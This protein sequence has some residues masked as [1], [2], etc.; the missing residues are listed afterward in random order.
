[1]VEA[2]RGDVADAAAGGA[3]ALLPLLLVT[4]DRDRLVEAAG[5]LEGAAPDRD[6]RAPRQRH[7]AVGRAGVEGGDRRLLTAAG[8]RAAALQEGVDRAGEDVDLGRRVGCR[9]QRRQPRR[10]RPHV[11][12]DEDQQLARGG[13]DAGVAGGVGA[14]RRRQG[15]DARRAARRPR[16]WPDRDRRAPPRPRR[17][18]PPPAARSTRAR[19]RGSR[20][21]R[22]SARRWW[23]ALL[24]QRAEVARLRQVLLAQPR[25]GRRDS[26]AHADAR[27]PAEQLS[28]SRPTAS[29]ARR[30]PRRSA[31]APVSNAAGSS[32]HSS[33]MIRA[34][35][36]IVSSSEAE[37]LKSSLSAAGGRSRRRSRRRCRRCG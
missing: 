11:V 15:D 34:V 31:G 26:L 37:M 21:G 33:Q 5:G 25:D 13:V 28:P 32:P 2:G 12:V 27:F 30:R 3:V 18:P 19:R 23:R 1:M 24:P 10:R 20:A 29:G 17:R 9:Q 35:S 36:A 14:A 6:V 22:A 16:R 4:A 8:A 7:V